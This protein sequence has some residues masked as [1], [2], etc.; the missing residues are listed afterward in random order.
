MRVS[1]PRAA[2]GCL[3]WRKRLMW[4]TKASVRAAAKRAVA[5]E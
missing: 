4:L 3:P 2:G 5:A 1:L